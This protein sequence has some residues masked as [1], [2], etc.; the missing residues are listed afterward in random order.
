M[1]F[2]AE[3]HKGRFI[4]KTELFD[5]MRR[6]YKLSGMNTD[7]LIWNASASWR[8]L[9]GKGKLLLEVEDILNHADN[10]TS[11]ESANQQVMTWS[12]Q[13]HHYIRLGFT[14]HLDAKEKK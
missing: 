12:D 8:C 2:D 7:C 1:G 4:V 10:F 11:N 14:Y 5:R 3:L 6:G 9:K 13:M